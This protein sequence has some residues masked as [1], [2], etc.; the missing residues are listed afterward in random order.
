MDFHRIIEHGNYRTF[1]GASAADLRR[2]IV[3]LKLTHSGT[4]SSFGVSTGVG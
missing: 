2:G 3:S 1:K 4:F